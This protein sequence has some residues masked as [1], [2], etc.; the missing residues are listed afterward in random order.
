VK[1]KVFTIGGFSAHADQRDLLEWV[2]HFAESKPKVFVVHGEI[3]ASEAL[4]AAIHEK[5]EMEAH[6]PKWKESLMFKVREA[7][8]EKIPYKVETIDISQ[9]MQSKVIDLE[10]EI[11]RLKLRLKKKD[12]KTAIAKEDVDKLKYIEEELQGI[13]PE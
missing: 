6:F 3:K 1:A 8:R 2:S 4:A 5:F 13:L 10:H 12:E 7:A 9:T 11:E